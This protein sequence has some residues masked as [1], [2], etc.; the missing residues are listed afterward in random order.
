M[1][2]D[3]SL[4]D[5]TTCHYT[6]MCLLTKYDT[7]TWMTMGGNAAICQMEQ[8]VPEHPEVCEQTENALLPFVDSTQEQAREQTDGSTSTHP[9][10]S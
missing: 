5:C 3:S 1:Y 4:I 8:I 7:L 9:H 10:L 2:A 6:N